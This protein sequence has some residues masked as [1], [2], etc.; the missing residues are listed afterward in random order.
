ME[1]HHHRA[2]CSS[3]HLWIAASGTKIIAATEPGFKSHSGT[4]K[5]A[6]EHSLE[7]VFGQVERT[8]MHSTVDRV[9]LPHACKSSMSFI[10]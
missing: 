5:F 8:T 4:V 2:V 3:R 6:G 9:Q 1:S 10:K 7:N